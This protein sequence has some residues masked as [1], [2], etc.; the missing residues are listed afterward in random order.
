MC[1]LLV[2]DCACMHG[3]LQATPFSLAQA[4]WIL[5]CPLTF[6]RDGREACMVTNDHNALFEQRQQPLVRAVL[7]QLSFRRLGGP[8]EVC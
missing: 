3:G 5:D 2:L 8:T 1:L 6:R 4:P 7:V